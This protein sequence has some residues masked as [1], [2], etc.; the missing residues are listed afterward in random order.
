MGISKKKIQMIT[1]AD[2]AKKA[3]VSQSTASFVLNNRQAELRISDGTRER[4]LVAARELGYRRNEL[5]RAVGSGKNFVLGFL[6][7][8]TGEFETRI[9]EG[10]LKAASEAGYLLKLLFRDEQEDFHEVARLCVEQRLAGLVTRSFFKAEATEAFSDELA[11]YGIPIVFVDD[12]LTMPLTSCVTSDDELGYRLTIEHLV[13]LGHRNI[14]FIAGDS[15]HPQSRMRKDI[16]R[17]IMLEYGLKAPEGSIVDANWNLERVDLLTRRLFDDQPRPAGSASAPLG[18]P[19]ALICA[20]D[21][22]AA[23]AIRTLDGMGLRVPED[24]SVV[25]YSDF[26]FA[27]LLSPSLT[28][29]SQPFEEIGAVAARILL[30][31]LKDRSASRDLP[32]QVVL[33]TKLV[34]RDSTAVSP[35]V[36]L[37]PGY[38]DRSTGVMGS[39]GNHLSYISSE[40][41]NNAEQ[42][43][44]S[45]LHVN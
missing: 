34:V 12:N 11:S 44:I 9:L 28:T 31:K 21:E 6:K 41:E 24:V 14:A 30:Q 8:D 43:E 2:V 32:S 35:Y 45:G 39:G 38:P 7:M 13:E 22:L 25:G 27:S 36:R 3:G 19:T 29:I 18:R 5:A 23:V 40:G 42:T 33:P 1:M 4:V 20:G 16:Y 17:R 37:T 26:S 10:V 15:V